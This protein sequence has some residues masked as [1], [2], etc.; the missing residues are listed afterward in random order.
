MCKIAELYESHVTEPYFQ[1][2][3][4]MDNAEITIEVTGSVDIEWGDE[5]KTFAASGTVKH[6]YATEGSYQ[7]TFSNYELLE[8]MEISGLKIFFKFYH[9]INAALFYDL[10]GFV[11]LF[12][13]T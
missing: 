7:I 11:T 13:T 2:K 4:K 10:F 6:T 9:F 12:Y 3:T 5:T 1:F 8:G